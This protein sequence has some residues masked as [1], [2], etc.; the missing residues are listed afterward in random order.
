MAEMFAEIQRLVGKRVIVGLK[1]GKDLIDIIEA[2]AD[3]TFTTKNGMIV[4]VGA[5]ATI[6]AL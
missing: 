5:V 3:G 4:D 1:S 6:K 2:A